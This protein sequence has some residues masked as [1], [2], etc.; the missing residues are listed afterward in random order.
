VVAAK[1]AIEINGLAGMVI[2]KLD[3]LSGLKKIKVCTAYE[4]DGQP[5]KWF[6]PDND[7]LSHATPVYETLAG[8]EED[9]SSITSFEKLPLTAQEYVK[10]LEQLMGIPISILSVGPGREQKIILDGKVLF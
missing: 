6:P 9:I 7:M 5:V 4:I 3:V 10:R 1:Y 8:W 2:T